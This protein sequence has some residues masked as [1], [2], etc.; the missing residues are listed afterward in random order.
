MTEDTRRALEIIYPLAKELGISVDADHRFL[1]VNNQAIGIMAN[2]THA[3]IMEFIGY[4][5][6]VYAKDRR[7]HIPETL[8]SR[9]RWYWYTEAQLKQLGAG[10]ASS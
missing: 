6:F 5:I 7:V 8:S 10:G 3:T 1:Y 2:S 9:I 4:L